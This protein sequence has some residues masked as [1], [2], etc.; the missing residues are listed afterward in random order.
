M[1]LELEQL[2]Q[3]QLIEAQA[4]E[5]VSRVLLAAEVA[6]QRRLSAHLEAVEVLQALVV[7]V[8]AEVVAA[9]GLDR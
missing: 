5:R 2:A 3:G 1:G 4:L 7:A 8:V 9:L 6:V